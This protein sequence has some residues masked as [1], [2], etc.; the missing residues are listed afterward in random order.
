[1]A[2]LLL[3]GRFRWMAVLAA[4]GPVWRVMWV[5]AMGVLREEWGH[6][7]DSATRQSGFAVWAKSRVSPPNACRPLR[8]CV[9]PPPRLERLLRLTHSGIDKSGSCPKS[10]IGD[11]RFAISEL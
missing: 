11:K 9:A 10:V 5:Y 6:L 2:G 4:A 1:M 8:I 3:A 7:D